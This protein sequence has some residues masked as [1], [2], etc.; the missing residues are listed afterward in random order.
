MLNE[1]VASSGGGST[2]AC[3][4]GPGPG[5]R[6]LSG[7]KGGNGRVGHRQ[8]QQLLR[9]AVWRG[10]EQEGVVPRPFPSERPG[11]KR[12]RGVTPGRLVHPL[13]QLSAEDQLAN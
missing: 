4:L 11:Q 3:R 5:K 2:G 10:A 1:Y 7:R 13:R 9:L 6:R 12:P 8:Q